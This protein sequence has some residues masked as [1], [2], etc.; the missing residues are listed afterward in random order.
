ML[1][2]PRRRRVS[3]RESDEAVACCN[4]P[5]EVAVEELE[6]VDATR[7]T[8]PNGDFAGAPE[9][10]FRVALWHP[11]EAA[12][13][14]PL[15]VYSHGF[16]STRHGG[17]HLAQHLA[18]H[19]Y[20]VVATD[21]PLTTFTAPGGPE[22]G[23]VVNQPG[24]VSFLIDTVLALEGD[25]RP[26]SGE[27]DED[28]IGVFGLSLGGLTTT[29]VAFHPE[30]RDPRVR[31]AISIGGPGVMF[32]SRYFDHADVPFLMIAGTAD[33]MIDFESNAKPIPGR[34]RDGGLLAIAGGSHAGFSAQAAGVMR[35][36]GNPD[37]LGCTA[38]LDNID[39]DPDTNPFGDLGTEEQGFLDARGAPLPCQQE[40]AEVM[41]AG[42]QHWITALA[43]RAFF[44][45][46]FARDAAA[47]AAHAR[48]LAEELPSELAEVAYT[49]ASRS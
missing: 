40:F 19:G 6:W 22:A 10:R 43:A 29:L 11:R 21:Y 35:V 16:M 41:P 26:F 48:F 37:T 38:L 28:R 4:R 7:P 32:G 33:A 14:H 24:D 1:R 8:A 27:I 42:R 15:V 5:H 47:R 44:E 39:V 31:A 25:A 12:G 18:S 36:L 46:H 17:E 9:R 2:R 13:P 20:V 34:V 23:D 49:P 45:S 30:Q 3:R